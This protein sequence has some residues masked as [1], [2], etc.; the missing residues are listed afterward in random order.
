MYI[1]IPDEEL[2]LSQ[3]IFNENVNQQLKDPNFNLERKELF[4]FGYIHE[5][6]KKETEVRIPAS[7]IT[8]F[9]AFYPISIKFKALILGGRKFGGLVFG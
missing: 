6:N 2:K 5:W 9:I 4:V 3:S 8:A 1:D 7:L